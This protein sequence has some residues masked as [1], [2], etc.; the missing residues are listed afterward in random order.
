M[1]IELLYNAYEQ[2][3]TKESVDKLFE[4]IN[5]ILEDGQYV[6]DFMEI[7][8]NKVYENHYDY[9][10]DNL[11]GIKEVKVAIISRLEL[12]VNIMASASQYIEGAIPEIR[13]LSDEFYRGP[14]Q[15][16][17]TKLQ[18]LIEGIEWINSGAEVIAGSGKG[19][20][21]KS[22]YVEAASEMRNKL[23]ELE[24]A[25]KTSDMILIGDLL[26]YEIIPILESIRNA[27][28]DT[29]CGGVDKDESN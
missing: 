6:F 24:E 25:I 23:P 2:E 7:D 3:N 1:R 27:A 12:A 10:M 21:G 19:F 15:G 20:D 26:S 22:G 4:S 8:G 11:A 13:V 14:S 28:E 9:F 5:G 18:Q 29:V 16:T 17:W